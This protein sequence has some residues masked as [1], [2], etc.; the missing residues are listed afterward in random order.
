MAG[1]SGG[2]LGTR[3]RR[4]VQ[5]LA[6]RPWFAALGRRLA[7]V[8]RLLYRATGG[9]LTVLG[10]QGAAMPRTCLLTTTGRRSGRARTTPVM[11]LEHGA[12]VGRLERELRSARLAAWA[13]N[14]DSDPLATV[15]V[16]NTRIACRARRATPAEVDR[17]W[18]RLVSAW[19]AHEDYLARSGVRKMFVLEPAARE[20]AA[21]PIGG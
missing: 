12:C 15:Q 1:E 14:L 19:P 16:G 21:T 6:R 17:F 10:P 2:Q 20:A 13:L 3:Y 4:S 5:R 18:P 9:R 8:D 11:Y 7:P